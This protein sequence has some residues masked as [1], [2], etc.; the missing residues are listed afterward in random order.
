MEPTPPSGPGRSREIVVHTGRGRL[1]DAPLGAQEP[2]GGGGE[3]RFP[4][5]E[6][7]RILRERWKIVTA[8][9][10]V[11]TAGVA[12]GVA[13]T[14][15]VYRA[16]GTIEIRKQSAEVVSSDALFQFERISDQYLETEYGTL[17]SRALLRR[18]AADPV[19]AERIREALGMTPP[20]GDEADGAVA[21]A[22]LVEAMRD[23]VLVD[24]VV[25]SRMIRVGFDS[26][27]PELS[28]DVA[29]AL[30]AHYGDMRRGAVSAA[31]V[32]LTEQTDS[33][34]RGLLQAEGELQQY[35]RDNELGSLVV[36]SG[37]ASVP[38]ERLRRLQQELTEAEA[39]GY[40]A[41]AISG[42]ARQSE[43]SAES[44]LLKTLRAR[45]ATLEGEYASASTVF[46]DSF[47]RVRRL[48]SELA[49]LDSLVAVEQGRVSGAATTQ[50]EAALRRRDLLEG[51]VAQQRRIVEAF[52]EKLA[53][54]DRRRRDV[55]SLKQ[56]YANMQQTREEA[57]V[58]AA[59]AAMDIAVM[60]PAAPPLDP[61]RPRPKRDL[62]LA[63]MTGLLLG[64][65]LAFLREFSDETVRSPQEMGVFGDVPLL[66][67]IPTAAA[68]PRPAIGRENGWHRIDQG[69]TP[70]SPIGEA[71]RGLRTSVLFAAG[72]ARPRTLL[73]TSGS[74]SEG[75][76]TV[77]TNLAISLAMLGHRVLLVD[78]DLRRPAQHR[79]F[80]LPLSPGLAE[81]L[82]GGTS[83]RQ[84]RHRDVRRGL[85]VLPAGAT[86]LSASDLLAGGVVDRWLEEAAAEY[87]FVLVDSPALHIHAPDARILAHAV[88]GVLLVARSGSTSREV[89]RRAVADTPHLV[90]V[91]LNRISPH[92]LP[93]YYG[94][95]PD[96]AG[97]VRAGAGPT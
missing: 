77:S 81:Y 21:T 14:P 40:R 51:A 57:S 18:A 44:D 1:S 79:V 42:A 22:R 68:S 25:G 62:A 66:A 26:P 85:D 75:K 20:P 76:T 46:T 49:R 93:L 33:V 90:G 54:Y 5:A 72:G 48:R 8:A 30:I 34:R 32:R 7:A 23:R 59:L 71:F 69:P 60:E 58:S 28:A 87:D 89:L 12:V 4:L 94:P 6:Y 15:P 73:V 38:H 36:G 95:G 11:V 37:D 19:L 24:P 97:E 56:L 86:G 17:R 43:A 3:P 39:A 31:I 52:A 74:P 80:G 84:T 2:R 63:A 65:G 67:S 50:Y 16:V 27:D 45:I 78:A 41:A 55:E 10:V 96:T 35:V 9:F 70:D 91:V 53:E 82:E 92:R 29:N 64:V 13:L 47:P 61:L 83:W 88:E